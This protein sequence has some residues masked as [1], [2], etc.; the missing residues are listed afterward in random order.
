[1][2]SQA[3]SQSLPS[4]EPEEGAAASNIATSTSSPRLPPP[5]LQ[6]VPAHTERLPSTSRQLTPFLL[7]SDDSSLPPP[8]PQF[9]YWQV[10]HA[11]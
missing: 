9:V 6:P 3:A 4:M 8:S 10:L 2:S 7:V 11:H 5:P 1:M